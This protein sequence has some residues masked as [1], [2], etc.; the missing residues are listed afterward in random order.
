MCTLVC[1]ESCVFFPLNSCSV[2][3]AGCSLL[4]VLFMCFSRLSSLGIVM[5][6]YCI[7]SLNGTGVLPIF[8]GLFYV[9]LTYYHGLCVI[10]FYVNFQR[11][12][13]YK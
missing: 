10:G 8:M 12:V 3:I 5:P 6:R 11:K 2:L 1:L 13:L 9:P 4:N 7:S